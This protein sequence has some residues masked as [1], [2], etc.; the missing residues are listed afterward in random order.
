MHLHWLSEIEYD[1]HPSPQLQ[2][3][4]KVPYGQTSLFKPGFSAV[5]MTLN[6]NDEVAFVTVQLAGIFSSFVFVFSVEV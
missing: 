3:I 2:E 1:P 4:A 5:Y 6:S